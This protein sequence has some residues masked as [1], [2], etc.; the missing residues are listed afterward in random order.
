MNRRASSG[1]ADQL[2]AVNRFGDIVIA[3]GGETLHAVATSLLF[4][5]IVEMD[6]DHDANVRICPHEWVIV[7]AGNGLQ[8]RLGETCSSVPV[9]GWR[10]PR[11]I[12]GT[13]LL[14]TLGQSSFFVG[15]SAD[16]LRSLSCSSSS[17]RKQPVWAVWNCRAERCQSGTGVARAVAPEIV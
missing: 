10:N 16:R 8:G 12:L 1:K 11:W 13:D 7:V 14:P 6:L 3:T 4:H 5:P 2:V 17:E 9:D 15:R